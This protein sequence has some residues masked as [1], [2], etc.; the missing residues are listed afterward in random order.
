MTDHGAIQAAKLRSPGPVHLVMLV[1]PGTKE[2]E[3]IK[4]FV[5]FHQ[6]IIWPLGKLFFLIIFII[7]IFLAVYLPP[8]LH[9]L[10]IQLYQFLP[11]KQHLHVHVLPS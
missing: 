8:N 10:L 9:L 11:N 6:S 1:Y 7:L 5:N 2:L 4:V 3:V